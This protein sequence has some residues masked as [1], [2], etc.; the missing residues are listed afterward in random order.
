MNVTALVENRPSKTDSRLVAE[1]GLSLH[2]T[3]RGQSVLF[4]MGASGAFVK[5]A[6]HLLVDLASVKAAVLSHHHV[7]HGGGLRQ[8]LE[9]NSTAN[10]YLGDAPNGDCVAKILGFVKKYVGLDKRMLADYASRLK[11]ITEP[12]QIL[13]DVF[14][15][16]HI[17]SAHPKPG[18]NKHIFLQR[19]GALVLD[20]FTHEIVM[21]I[22]EAGKLV[23]FTGCAHNGILNMVDTVAT[24]FRG[25]P[26]KAVIGGF[27]LIGVPPFNFMADTKPEV[28]DL[29]RSIL[30]YPVAETYTGHCTGTQ[31]FRVLKAVMGDRLTD[32]HTG[33][34]FEV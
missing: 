1:W 7:D 12:T 26:I 14:L 11:T 16:P 29:G 10:V 32:M 6:K 20:D 22:K 17:L 19:D 21:A 4:D 13:P 31:A 27:H 15:L 24:E 2:I 25:T 18:G 9:L 5:N 23:V 30:N 8:F 33:S 28:E 34:R 3:F